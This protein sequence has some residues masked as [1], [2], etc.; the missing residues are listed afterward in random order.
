MFDDRSRMMFEDRTEEA[1]RTDP[2][3][4]R[5]YSS[6]GN[7]SRQ[8]RFSFGLLNSVAPDLC[9]SDPWILFLA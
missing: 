4:S 3:D 6:H 8:S 5:I 7:G 9:I 1:R 2:T